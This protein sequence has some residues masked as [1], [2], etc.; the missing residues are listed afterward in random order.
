LEDEYGNVTE[1]S[2]LRFTPQLACD[3]QPEELAIPARAHTLSRQIS[4]VVAAIL[5]ILL[6]LAIVIRIRVQRPWLI[7][8]T[9]AVI[10][11][12]LALWIA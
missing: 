4:A 3:T 7:A 1:L 10:L 9:G 5:A 6:L 2:N 8:H 12:A 11:L